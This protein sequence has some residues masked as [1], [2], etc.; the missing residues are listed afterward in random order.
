[1]AQGRSDGKKM[2]TR[3][4]VGTAEH[5]AHSAAVANERARAALVPVDCPS[6]KNGH[7]AE[8]SP[9]AC[10]CNL[11]FTTSSGVISSEVASAPEQADSIRCGAV[12]WSSPTR[13]GIAADR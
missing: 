9:P 3:L 7:A 4:H 11:V 8:F 1:M 2:Q 13:A 10:A 6:N 5:L 12:I